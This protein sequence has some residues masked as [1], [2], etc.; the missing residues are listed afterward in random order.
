VSHAQDQAQY[1]SN[2]LRYEP[3]RRLIKHQHPWLSRQGPASR[4]DTF[5]ART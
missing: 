1:F 2:D 5:S 3:H 4:C